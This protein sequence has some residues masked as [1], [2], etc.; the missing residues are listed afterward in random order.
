MLKLDGTNILLHHDCRGLGLSGQL[1][2]GFSERSAAPVLVAG[3]LVFA[4]ITAGVGHTCG[5]L[6]NGSVACW[7]CVNLAH[8]HSLHVHGVSR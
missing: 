2:N 5:L 7:G 8:C 4:S 1:G 6:I 3:D